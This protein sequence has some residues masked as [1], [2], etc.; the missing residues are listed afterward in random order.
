MKNYILVLCIAICPVLV[1]AQD[2]KKPAKGGLIEF[3]QRERIKTKSQMQKELQQ[4]EMEQFLKEVDTKIFTDDDVDMSAAYKDGEDA[5]YQFIAQH[6]KLSVPVDAEAPA[7]KYQVF[8]EFTVMKDGTLKNVKAK[9]SFGFGMEREAERVIKK[10]NKQWFPAQLWGK[11][12]MSQREIT[13]TFTL[14]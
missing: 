2:T 4:K 14:L 1:S 9:T 13:V 3:K 6:L 10:T 12:V 5:L 8:V 11:E 7:G